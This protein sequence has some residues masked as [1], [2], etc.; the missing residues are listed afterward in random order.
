MKSF[1][2]MDIASATIGTSLERFQKSLIEQG[3][4]LST[5]VEDTYIKKWTG[6]ALAHALRI[7]TALVLGLQ[8]FLTSRE[9][10]NIDRV[11][12]SPVT[13]PLCHNVEHVPEIFFQGTSYRTT[14][15][16][17]YSK[18][19]ACLNP[20]IQGVYI[21]SP[22][23]RLELPSE[24]SRHKY[25]IDFSQMDIELKRTAF[26]S[27]EDYF[28]RPTQT[29]AALERERDAALDFFEDMIVYSVKKILALAGDSLSELGVTLAVP[30]KPFPRF[31]KD[32]EEDHESA[33]LEARLGRKAN[34][35]FFWVLG[36][37]RENY[38]LVYPYLARD[39]KRPAKG[40]ISS[41]QVYNYDLCAAPLY[42]DGTLGS[43]YEVLSGGLREWVYEAIVERL[44]DNGILKEK[45]QFD[46][47]GN[48]LNVAALE[49]YGPFLA[50][51]QMRDAHGQGLFP[52]VFGGG[53]GI[54]RTL[55]A[56]LH[57]SKIEEIDQ[58][59]CFGKNPDRTLPFLF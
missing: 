20:F 6:H 2:D 8:E 55:F 32:E 18:M 19:L 37:L 11:S 29:V 21:D 50:V 40:T 23:I 27:E 7:R 43:A 53:L 51:A 4:S 46:E 5:Y 9:I 17:M 35:Q 12:L 59:T 52:Q 45:P 48:L 24:T 22:N 13:D 1:L 38:D 26:L 16:M 49:G 41:R 34:A 56:L 54:E 25:L 47:K 28:D 15:S 57:G 10:L 14:H 42:P 58:L 31:Y 39:G 30:Q 36:L 3:T 44:L 33:T